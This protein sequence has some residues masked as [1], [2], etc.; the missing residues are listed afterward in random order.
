[1]AA[2]TRIELHNH[3]SESDGRFTPEQL[4]DFMMENGIPAFAM[5]DHNTLSGH[6]KMKALLQSRGNPCEMVEG[7]EFTTFFGHILCLNMDRYFSW[8]DL[9]PDRPDAWLERIRSCGAKVGM[10]HPDALNH[11]RWQLKVRDWQLIDFIEV[12]NNAQPFETVNVSAIQR[13][14]E[15]VLRGFRIAATTGLDLHGRRPLEGCF[16]TY[17]PTSLPPQGLDARLPQ[18]CMGTSLPLQA[19]NASPA[20]N[21]PSHIGQQLGYAIATQQT[22]VTRGP[23]LIA[24][25]TG[26]GIRCA[27]EG[28]TPG[29]RPLVIELRTLSGSS[30]YPWNA[31]EKPL[32]IPFPQ[33][34]TLVKLHEKDLGDGMSRMTDIPG[35]LAIAPVLYC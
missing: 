16:T 19:M 5:T 17:I 10:A 18:Q 12:I 14:E 27:L 33:Q 28:E 4:L 23:L 30:T 24:E 9:D 3:T 25:R 1:M 11:T 31:P 26:G 34:T 22:L 8:H 35:L 2:W 13:W 20:E 21:N 7:L 6:A 32:F 15:L 29:F